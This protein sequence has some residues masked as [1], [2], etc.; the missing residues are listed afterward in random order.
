MKRLLGLALAMGMLAML[1]GCIYDPGYYRHPGVV[2]DDE[3]GSYVAPAG[4]YYDDGYADDGYAPAYYYGADYG[5]WCCY[6]GW[7]PWIGVGFYGNFYRGWHNGG[8]HGGGWHGS[9]SGG[10]HG[11]SSGHSGAHH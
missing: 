1:A 4:G 9:H 8:Y 3:R 7:Y 5:P 2:Y 10:W 6:G 11:S